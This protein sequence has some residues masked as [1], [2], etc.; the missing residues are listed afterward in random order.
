M[1]VLNKN[2]RTEY[3]ILDYLSYDTTVVLTVRGHLPSFEPSF[4]GASPPDPCSRS[5]DLGFR[6][7]WV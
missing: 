5:E 3:I 1:N 4:L 2:E 7:A 6:M